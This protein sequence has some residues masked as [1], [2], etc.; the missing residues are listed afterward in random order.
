M[1]KKLKNLHRA[2]KVEI[3]ERTNSEWRD[4]YPEIT[5]YDPAQL[6][7]NSQDSTI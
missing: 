1:E 3:I 7:R 4:L 5:P 6:L 2:K